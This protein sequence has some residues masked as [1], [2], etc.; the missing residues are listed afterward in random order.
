MK[1][2]IQFECLICDPSQLPRGPFHHACISSTEPQTRAVL[3]AEFREMLDVVKTEI[4]YHQEKS[5]DNSSRPSAPPLSEDPRVLSSDEIVMESD[6]VPSESVRLSDVS[7]D[8]MSDE[9][10]EGMTIRD[11]EKRIDAFNQSRIEKKLEK[12]GCLGRQKGKCRHGAA[13]NLQK[14][15][16][17]DKN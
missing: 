15:V 14:L 17:K 8:I 10:I 9:D 5:R 1:I 2:T 13:K 16:F 12:K 7:S 4:I 6:D 3:E 11:I